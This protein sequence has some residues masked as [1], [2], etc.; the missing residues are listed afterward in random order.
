MIPDV[1]SWKAFCHDRL[2]L[3]MS[4]IIHNSKNRGKKVDIS[5][6]DNNLISGAL[7][8]I[9][10][11]TN[12]KVKTCCFLEDD[13]VKLSY[14][15]DGCLYFDLCESIDQ[16]ISLLSDFTP[17][18]QK[19]V[20][21]DNTKKQLNNLSNELEDCKNRYDEISRQ[22]I[23]L[24]N[25]L[26]KLTHD[27]SVCDTATSG[28]M[29]TIV[30]DDDEMLEPTEEVMGY[31]TTSETIPSETIHPATS[32][33]N[34]E[35]LGAITYPDVRV[36]IEPNYIVPERTTTKSESKS[37]VITLKTPK[38][39]SVTTSKSEASKPETH[40]MRS[41]IPKSRSAAPKEKI[42]TKGNNIS[43]MYDKGKYKADKE[44][45][46]KNK[47][48]GIEYIEISSEEEVDNNHNDDNVENMDLN[49]ENQP[50]RL[51]LLEK[52]K[53]LREILLNPQD[54]IQSKSKIIDTLRELTSKSIKRLD[55]ISAED[56]ICQWQRQESR[57][58][59]FQM[60]AESYDI[61][62]LMSLVRVYEDILK[63]GEELIKDPNNDI[64]DV[65]LWVI[66]FLCDKMKIDCK[67]EQKNR[68]G[69]SRLCKLFSEGITSDQLVQA[70]C[71]KCDFFIK[72]EYYNAFLS[73][74]PSLEKRQ[75]ISSNNYLKEILSFKI[76]NID[77]DNL[78]FS[79]PKPMYNN[80][81]YTD[82][83]EI[84]SF[85]R[86]TQNSENITKNHNASNK[87]QKI[88]FK[89]HLGEDFSDVAHKYKE[90]EYIVL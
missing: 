41:T 21:L 40:N 20:E 13:V 66:E 1:L 89:L 2:R 45:L 56:R 3:M 32:E 25:E 37:T 53:K 11:K 7:S 69:C 54:A 57:C 67:T 9:W 4:S 80:E 73:Q 17:L 43:S 14:R 5:E 59:R 58:D 35:E 87:K 6:R 31:T 26:Q 74:I 61:L 24:Q 29:D 49:P 84:L 16:I 85:T 47:K 28:T 51:L 72:Q 82:D 64:D 52:G 27:Q 15:N 90:D 22:N 65:K 76:S 83:I 39:E 79:Q 46:S 36:I 68:L 30:S 75:S 19:R 62:H 8:L 42:L 18:Q 48:R 38:L 44:K 50:F 78:T 63:V 70:G 12:Q 34:F 88:I 77:L 23:S 71:F 81:D 33:S 60:D 86:N 10:L 55:E